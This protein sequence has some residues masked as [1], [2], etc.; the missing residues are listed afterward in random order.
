MM[1]DTEQVIRCTTSN[2]DGLIALI[3]PEES[4]VAKWQRIGTFSSPVLFATSLLLTYFSFP[5]SCRAEKRVP[6]LYAVK[7]EGNLPQDLQER[8]RGG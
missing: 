4:W 1:Q 2:Y 3:K 8:M 5:S 6:G 7:T